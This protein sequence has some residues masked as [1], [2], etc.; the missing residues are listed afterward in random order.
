MDPVTGA[1]TPE[2]LIQVKEQLRRERQE[3][4][5]AGRVPGDASDNNWVER[6]PNNVGG[7]VRAIMFD[8]NDPTF[9]KEFLLVV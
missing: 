2:K 5:A 8:P 1:P 3:A 7:R 6:G 9:K 4:L